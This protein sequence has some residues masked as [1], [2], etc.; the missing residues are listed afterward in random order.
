VLWSL[1]PGLAEVPLKELPGAPIRKFA[2][3]NPDHAPYGLRAKEALEH[4]GVWEALSPGWCWARTSPIPPSSSTRA[5]PMRASWPWPWCSRPRWRG[6]GA[7]TL[8]PAEW[9]E[10]LEQG[11]VILKRAADNPLAHRFADYMGA[12]PRGW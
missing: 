11:Y 9:H 5:R 4:Q 12:S 8:I 6:K 2:I 10:P 1:K 7:W 3:A